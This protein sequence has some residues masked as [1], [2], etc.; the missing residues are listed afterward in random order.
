MFQRILRGLGADSC[1]WTRLTSTF[2][3]QVANG[4]VNFRDYLFLQNIPSGSQSLSCSANMDKYGEGRP[5]LCGLIDIEIR[6]YL[7]FLPIAVNYVKRH[8]EQLFYSP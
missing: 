8:P 2:A 7:G 1:K 4:I 3:S 6:V 5:F